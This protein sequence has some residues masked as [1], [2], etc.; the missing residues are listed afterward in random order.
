MNEVAV[1]KFCQNGCGDTLHAE[2]LE[3][4]E[5]ERISKLNSNFRN[6]WKTKCTVCGTEH[7]LSE[8]MR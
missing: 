8:G 6:H 3:G 4:E 1:P 7:Y 2:K 5:L